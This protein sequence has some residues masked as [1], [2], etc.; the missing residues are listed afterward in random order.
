MVHKATTTKSIKCTI[1]GHERVVNLDKPVYS[2]SPYLSLQRISSVPGNKAATEV[3]A[4]LKLEI[5]SL[6]DEVDQLNLDR[7]KRSN[8]LIK[9]RK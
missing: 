5:A 9:N 8:F 6:K 1:F 2:I 7:Q 3:I 4:A